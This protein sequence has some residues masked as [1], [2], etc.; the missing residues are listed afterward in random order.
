MSVCVCVRAFHSLSVFF[1]V[2]F[3]VPHSFHAKL[4][5]FLYDFVLFCC[6]FARRTVI[7]RSMAGCYIV[8]RD[9]W[10]RRQTKALICFIF[11]T[12][13][14]FVNS[15]VP[16][17]WIV[18]LFSCH[19]T[20]ND[21]TNST[22]CTMLLHTMSSSLFHPFGGLSTTKNNNQQQQHTQRERKRFYEMAKN[23]TVFICTW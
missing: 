6:I 10:K 5:L 20:I 19:Q 16:C 15:C 23:A 1:F 17:R 21:R 13:F 8:K 22:A 3:H 11:Y 2:S 9:R 7:A 18:F 14:V 4:L 12:Y